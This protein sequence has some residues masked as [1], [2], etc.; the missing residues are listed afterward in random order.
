MGIE[1][2]A[3]LENV[4]AKYI[5]LEAECSAESENLGAIDAQR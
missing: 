4:R 5:T 1:T 2:T 3:E